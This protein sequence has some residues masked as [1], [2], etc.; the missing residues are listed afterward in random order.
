MADEID[1]NCKHTSIEYD[2]GGLAQPGTNVML[3]DIAARCA[4]CGTLFK[5]LGRYNNAPRHGLP[6][7][8]EDGIWLSLPMIPEGENAFRLILGDEVSE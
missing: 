8:S 1:A 6:Y 7:V 5:W 2:V 4:D 3:T